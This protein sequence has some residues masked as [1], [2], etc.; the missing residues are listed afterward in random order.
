MWLQSWNLQNYRQQWFLTWRTFGKGNP[1]FEKRW[2]W[3]SILG[4]IVRLSGGIR[5]L[6]PQNSS[7]DSSLCQFIKQNEKWVLSLRKQIQQCVP[8]LGVWKEMVNRQLFQTV[9]FSKPRNTGLADLIHDIKAFVG[10]RKKQMK[11]IP[12]QWLFLPSLN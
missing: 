5:I 12:L 8:S 4:W 9:E 2:G 1:T 11:I 6:Q 3:F 10:L 7:C